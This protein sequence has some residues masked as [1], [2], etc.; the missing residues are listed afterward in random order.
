[1]GILFLEKKNMYIRTL[2]EFALG[3]FL[4]AKKKKKSDDSP[5]KL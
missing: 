2:L 1:M 3:P 4:K 5:L